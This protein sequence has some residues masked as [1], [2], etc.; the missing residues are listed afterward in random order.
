MQRR[1]LVTTALLAIGAMVSACRDADR[2]LTGSGKIGGTIVFTTPANP[3]SLLPPA[4]VGQQASPIVEMLFDYLADPDD[5][6]HVVGDHGFTPRLADH[7]TWAPDSLSIA[8]HVDPRARWHDGVPVRSADVAYTY[9]LYRSPGMGSTVAA[10]FAQM[11]S[12]S[13][14]DSLTAVFWFKRRYPLQFYD[15]A[16]S[17]RICPAHLLA[18]TPVADLRASEFARHPIGTGRYRFVRWLP[19]ELIEIVAD[20]AN[21]RG[22][23]NIDRLVWDIAPT[24]QASLVKLYSGEADML[25]IV[26]PDDAADVTKHGLRTVVYPQP[27]Y[28]FLGFNL[29]R[30]IFADRGVRLALAMALDR[31]SMVRNV[32]DTLG[33]VGRGPFSR[34]DLI[35]DST[36]AQI[37]YDTAR[38]GRLLDSLGWRRGPS[39]IRTRG[40]RT[41]A[42]EVLVPSS[43][44]F[45]MRMADLI[46]D[47]L[48]RIG[49]SASP[50]TFE[51]SVVL[52]R[53][54]AHDFDA[55]IQTWISDLTPNA[56]NESWSTEAQTNGINYF[57]YSNPIADAA[58]DSGVVEM[59]PGRAAAHFHHAFA[60]IAADVP[61]VW[62]YEPR[63]V[64]AINGRIHTAAFRPDGWWIRLADWYIPAG[65]R[66]AR[67]RVGLAAA[68]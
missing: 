4:I 14:P 34:L 27:A 37:P 57:G 53:I 60:V 42:F 28:G 58:I 40:G 17:L 56:P 1:R 54:A 13:T 10:S 12:V 16:N 43:S 64:A 41:L 7:W 50:R 38:A 21:Y 35:G 33:Y 26:H 31:Q 6:M 62:L 30:P 48:Q 18:K 68:R 45:R 32:L 20:T 44:K 47:Q 63:T 9:H 25:E 2:A 22:R 29:R 49:V 8:F 19:N 39:G 66:T 61:A 65:E 11:D 3:E 36:I 51:Q 15:A 52:G 55:T 24:Y 59:D 46:Q 67:D 5:S 23:P